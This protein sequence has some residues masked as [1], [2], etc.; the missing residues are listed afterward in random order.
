MKYL[1]IRQ[2]LTLTLF[3]LACWLTACQSGGKNKDL[4]PVA[5]GEKGEILVII[6]TV[7]WK[8]PLGDALKEVLKENTPGAL[9]PEPMFDVLPINPFKFTDLLK[10]HKSIIYVTTF[11]AKT[12][13]S[14]KLQKNFT[15]ASLDKIQNDSSLYM[16]IKEDEFARGQVVMH[17][18]GRNDEELIQN[19]KENKRTIQDFFNKLE[20]KR[21]AQHLFKVKGKKKLAKQFK[22]THEVTLT[23]PAGYKMAKDT[24]GF[25]WL[26]FPE[27][28]FDKNIFIAYKNYEDEAQFSNDSLIAWR[29]A[30]AKEHLYGNPDNPDSFVK[31]ETLE[32]PVIRQVKFQDKYAKEIRALWKT[33]N[34]SMGGP[35]VGYLFADSTS[36]RLY[37]IEGFLY[38]PSHDSKRELMRELE[39][40]LKSLST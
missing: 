8:G 11:D 25:F 29:N 24:T 37:Y 1:H 31:T 12:A 27:H 40:V 32:P 38:A 4:L 21:L 7:K 28:D 35:F 17:L 9:R 18:F 19:L 39:V 6:D 30:I 3:L 14:R 2:L 13:G 16:L 10:K 15:Q 26:R 5:K 36:G 22:E 34:I 20:A 33:N 23:I